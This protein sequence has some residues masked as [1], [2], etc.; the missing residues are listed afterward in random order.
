MREQAEAAT[1]SARNPEELEA[2]RVRYLGRKGELT[3]ILRQ[4]ASLS[5][6]ERPVVGQRAN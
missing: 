5:P 1:A 4:M 3:Q 6:E 2:V